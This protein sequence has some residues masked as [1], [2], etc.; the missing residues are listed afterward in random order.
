MTRKYSYRLIY[1]NTRSIHISD[2]LLIPIR[3]DVEGLW[4]LGE[5]V[6]IMKC[7]VAGGAITFRWNKK[8]EEMLP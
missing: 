2:V 6:G 8:T 3:A 5:S 1:G 7:R 4:V